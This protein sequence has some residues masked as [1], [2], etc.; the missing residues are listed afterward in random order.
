MTGCPPRSCRICGMK[1]VDEGK[2]G[3]L[4]TVRLC[5]WVLWRWSRVES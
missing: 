2:F 5:R 4:L 3:R 1:A